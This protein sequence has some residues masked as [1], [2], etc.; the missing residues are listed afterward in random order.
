LHQGWGMPS[1]SDTRGF[2][3]IEALIAAALVASAVVTL[4]H[5][6]A[7]GAAQTTAARRSISALVLA[8]SKL[9][10][11]RSAPFLFAADGSRVDGPA[12]ARSP[13]ASLVEDVDGWMEALDRFGDAATDR[14]PLH[15]LRRW[16]VRPLRDGDIDSLV[17]QVCVFA[18]DA[19]RRDAVADACVSSIRTRKP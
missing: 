14:Q 10:E 15:F 19:V 7:A 16:A 9:E 1:L 8:Q 12:L 4:A 11:L 5:L 13:E 2:S 3:L 6:V 17:L 18:S